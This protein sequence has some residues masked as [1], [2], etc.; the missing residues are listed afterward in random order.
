MGAPPQGQPQY[1]PWAGGVPAQPMTPAPTPDPQTNDGLTQQVTGFLFECAKG[2]V[3]G[4]LNMAARA[5]SAVAEP[6]GP[7]AGPLRLAAP[8]PGAPDLTS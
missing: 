1:A 7:V 2:L 4:M 5:A 8:R 6:D 3:G